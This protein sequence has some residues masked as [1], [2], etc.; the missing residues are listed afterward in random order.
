MQKIGDSSAEED[1]VVPFYSRNVFP[2]EI[3]EI[4][5]PQGRKI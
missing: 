2:T 5:F 1:K 4:K 3:C